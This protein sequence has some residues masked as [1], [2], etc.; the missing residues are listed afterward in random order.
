MPKLGSVIRTL[1]EHKGLTQA[2][3][4]TQAGLNQPYLSR[5]E[6]LSRERV[7]ARVLAKIAAV[8]GVSVEEIYITAG[9]QPSDD[10]AEDL[11]WK[12][13]QRVFRELSPGKQAEPLAIA[14]TL[15]SIDRSVVAAA[16][17]ANPDEYKEPAQ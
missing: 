7:D 1:R 3:L 14:H 17:I 8:L 11:R 12:Q 2:D 9:L 10:P 13:L 5:L 6:T 16:Q 4:A 15:S